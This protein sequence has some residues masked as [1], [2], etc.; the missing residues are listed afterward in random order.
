MIEGNNVVCPTVVV[1]AEPH[2]T[3]NVW[4]LSFHCPWCPR[5]RGKPQRH[6]HGGGELSGPPG[7]GHWG[8]DCEAREAPAE[9]DLLIDPA[10]VFEPMVRR[11]SAR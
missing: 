9:Y 8:S 7:L 6:T 2:Y 4:L 5:W 11:K 3:Q 10:Q 1:R